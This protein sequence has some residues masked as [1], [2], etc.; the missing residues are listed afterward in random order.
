[1]SGEHPSRLLASGPV[2]T[3]AAAPQGA[4]GEAQ[5]P[6]G[7]P[8]PAFSLTVDVFVGLGVAVALIALVFL[9]SS[10]IDQTVTGPN[11][12]SEIVITFLGVGACAA[13]V[14]VGGRGRAWGVGA[15]A[16]FA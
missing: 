11:T 13:A 3:L 6:S 7:R 9:T 8:I 1:M 5:A 16:L 10:S 4:G 2:S 14:V 12:W 15:A